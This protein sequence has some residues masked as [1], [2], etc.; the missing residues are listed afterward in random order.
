VG[1]HQKSLVGIPAVGVTLLIFC[2]QSSVPVV[3]INTFVTIGLRKARVNL[4]K[5]KMMIVTL[6]RM[7]L[8]IANFKAQV[9]NSVPCN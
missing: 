4:K 5:M 3:Q 9:V 8:L 6:M 7:T 1:V 2:V